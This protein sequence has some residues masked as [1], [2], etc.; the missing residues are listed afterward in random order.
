MKKMFNFVLLGAICFGLASCEM[1]KQ[2]SDGKYNGHA[3]VDLG[4]PSGTMWATT[5]FGA[6]F[7]EYMGG[8]YQW[9]ELNRVEDYL[10]CK[11]DTDTKY[12]DAE[13][14]PTLLPEDDVVA[15]KWGGKWR[16]PTQAELQE[17]ID[18]C[19]WNLDQKFN[20]YTI[21]GPNGNSIFIPIY[22]SDNVGMDLLYEYEGAVW[23]STNSGGKTAVVMVFNR[24]GR[25]ECINQLKK[26]GFEIRPV[27]SK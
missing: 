4:L 7:A 23:S 6:G 20:G 1:Y 16:I 12:D 18:K 22:G 15:Q 10:H 14:K 19:T 11:W 25:K 8:W 2:K 5:N 9:G 21:V 24:K 13:A 27:F 3:Y 17:L 26:Q